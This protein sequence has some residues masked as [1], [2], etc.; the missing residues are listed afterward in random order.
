MNICAARVPR[1]NMILFL[2]NQTR[3]NVDAMY[4]KKPKPPG[5]KAIG[6]YA[7]I[8]LRLEQIGRYT[9]QGLWLAVVLGLGIFTLAQL[10][11]DP[12]LTF[13]NRDTRCRK[14]RGLIGI[15]KR[16]DS[17]PSFFSTLPA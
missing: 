10:F 7:S 6:F 4:D 17:P 16:F 9:R 5:G 2:I 15:L 12:V 11:V 1:T 3:D 8:R 14:L 13:L